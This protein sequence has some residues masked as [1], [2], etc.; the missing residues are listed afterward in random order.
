MKHTTPHFITGWFFIVCIPFA[1]TQTNPVDT[2]KTTVQ[3]P[4]A[5]VAACSAASTLKSEKFNQG[6]ISD[7]L[8]LAQGK[9]A[10]FTLARPGSN[11]NEPFQVRL[12]GLSSFISSTAP[13]MVVNGIPGIDPGLID[14]NEITSITFLKDASA[15]ARYGMRGAAGVIL[16]ETRT[17]GE[18]PIAID[19]S[20]QL[21]VD[22]ASNQYSVFD[23]AAFIQNGGL[24]LSPQVNRQTD[25]QNEVL[26][27]GLSQ[28]H[29]LGIGGGLGQGH[30]SVGL[31][32]RTT[33]GIL[34]GSGLNQYSGQIGIEQR[35]WKNRIKING[36]LLA[37]RRQSD[38]G[39]SEAFRY[40]VMANPSSEIRSNDPVFQQFG[41]YVDQL[42]FDYYNPVAIIEQNAGRSRQERLTG[43]LGAE[44]RILNG[45][46]AFV[47]AAENRD[48][49]IAGEFY[50]PQSKWRG[51]GVN[52]SLRRIKSDQTNRYLESSVRYRR[53]IADGIGMD[54]NAGYAWQK[55]E[56]QYADTT[57]NGTLG[58][59]RESKLSDFEPLVLTPSSRYGNL[60]AGNN[61][62]VAYFGRIQMNFRDR[63]FV[64][65]GLRREG[66][67]RLGYRNKWGNFPYANAGLDLDKIWNFSKL[68]YLKLR[69]GYGITG[70]QP[71]YDGLSRLVL[72]PGA[73]FY[74]NGAYESGLGPT[75][76][77]NPD[78][79]W[80]E[81]RE[82]NI[83]LDFS[84]AHGK[85][86]GSL[87]YYRN[88][89]SDIIVNVYVPSP[90]NLASTTY[91]NIGEISAKG[92]E[93]TIG[94]PD[95]L[96]QDNFHWSTDLVFQTGKVTLEQVGRTDT[97]YHSSIGA[98]GFCCGG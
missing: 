24:D 21:A 62:L 35:F 64:E 17:G 97:F 44:V 78:L 98:P 89:V 61:T 85:I 82:I 77:E 12:R 73:L 41:G 48:N 70:Q 37:T 58:L 20:A 47:R 7:P 93:A 84:T 45:L 50:S 96:N 65:A 55:F 76:N 5:S 92:F 10:G 38:L 94:L 32:Y 23:A 83:G 16:L 15:A 4:L 67:S 51:Q 13:L 36:N 52:G 27:T 69:V 14:P 39:F 60:V 57:A 30:F 71:A 6:N 11:P 43:I 95:L 42:T 2:S 81:K 26:R 54:I 91:Q 56:Y 80:E 66:S 49:G 18:G 68:E 28:A 53:S 46:S 9:V 34:K 8:Q 88:T 31:N 3:T 40:A 72:S 79:K 74:N 1:F 63:Y 87:D 19:Y 22:Q 33:Q 86:T 90:P 59:N 25:W 75:L 29:H